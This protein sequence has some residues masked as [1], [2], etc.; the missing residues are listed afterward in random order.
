[1]KAIIMEQVSRKELKKVVAEIAGLL[2]EKLPTPKEHIRRLVI[3]RGVDYA[4]KLW[5]E[6]LAIEENGGMM[7]PDNTRRRTVG[8]VYFHLARIQLSPEHRALVFPSQWKKD[9]KLP[10]PPSVPL[11]SWN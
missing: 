11:L 2:G 9:L 5:E 6:T 3:L 7:L 4:R 1:M 8:G 10:K